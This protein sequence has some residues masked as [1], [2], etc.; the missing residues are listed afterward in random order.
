VGPEPRSSAWDPPQIVEQVFGS[1]VHQRVPF[2]STADTHARPGKLCRIDARI[3]TEN[4]PLRT[5]S[6]LPCFLRSASC[7]RFFPLRPNDRPGRRAAPPWPPYASNA[8][9]HRA[10]SIWK[11]GRLRRPDHFRVRASSS[12]AIA[13]GRGRPGKTLLHPKDVGKPIRRHVGNE[14]SREAAASRCFNIGWED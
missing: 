2:F 11:L 5:E 6:D 3:P 10:S 7:H 12:P 13:N 4:G 14:S 8:S 1:V 9:R